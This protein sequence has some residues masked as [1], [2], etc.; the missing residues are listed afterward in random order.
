[1]DK[2]LEASPHTVKPVFIVIMD[3]ITQ[4]LHAN[5]EC[6]PNSSNKRK[7]DEEQGDEETG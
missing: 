5:S 2:G 6:V 4:N 1:V 3:F 7:P